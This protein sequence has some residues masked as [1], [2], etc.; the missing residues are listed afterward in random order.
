MYDI[1]G[2]A[3]RGRAYSV[4]GA[5]LVEAAIERQAVAREKKKAPS[6]A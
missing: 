3:R 6:G 2:S 4:G 1:F 5:S